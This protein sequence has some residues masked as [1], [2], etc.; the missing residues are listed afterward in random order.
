MAF[1]AISLPALVAALT[2][3]GGAAL[4]RLAAG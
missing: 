2:R 1:A 3:L 4:L